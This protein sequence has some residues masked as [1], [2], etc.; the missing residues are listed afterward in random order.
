MCS[1]QDPSCSG[2]ELGEA[3]ELLQQLGSPTDTLVDSYLKHET[4][5]LTK[6][7]EEMQQQIRLI[8]D[9]DSNQ[10]YTMHSIHVKD[11]L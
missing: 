1:S 9:P 7:L 8:T 10:V 2:V 6:S 11:K 3:V 5:R 4:V